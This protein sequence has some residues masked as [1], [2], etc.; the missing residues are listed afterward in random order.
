MLLVYFVNHDGPLIWHMHELHLGFR[1]WT[2]V[3]SVFGSSTTEA[4]GLCQN[5]ESEHFLIEA[6]VPGARDTNATNIVSRQEYYYD[7][8]WE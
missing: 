4:F 5:E 7:T 6:V 1:C 3:S 8:S 2:H